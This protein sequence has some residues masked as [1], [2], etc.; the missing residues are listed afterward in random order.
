MIETETKYFPATSD[1]LPALALQITKLVDSYMLWIGV[2]ECLAE[3]V[4]QAPSRGKLCR[5]WA[6][7]MPSRF[8][9]AGECCLCNSR[10]NEFLG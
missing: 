7:A 4:K 2:T 8:V 5:D 6:C 1:G 3:E 9:S 10:L